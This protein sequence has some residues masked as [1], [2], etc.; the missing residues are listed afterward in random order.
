MSA[1]S[2]S[3]ALATPAFAWPTALFAIVLWSAHGVA[4]WGAWTGRWPA[5][6]VVAVASLCAYGSFTV[7]HEAVHGSLCLKPR[8]LNTVVAMLAAL[9]LMAPGWAFRFLHLEHH[10]HTNDPDQDPDYWNGRG[11]AWALPLRWAVADLAQ[12]AFYFR[13]ARGRPLAERVHTVV[14]LS[15]IAVAL[16]WGV[17]QGHGWALLW[18]WVIP[19][20][21]A[22][23]ALAFSF[24]FIVHRPH[25]VT[26]AQDRLRA[27]RILE[28]P[29]PVG[30]LLLGQHLHL[31]HHLHPGVPFY[32]Y[33][34][35]WN[36]LREVH[37]VLNYM[38]GG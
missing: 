25:A 8:T 31:L 37:A 32:R 38:N 7:L 4:L 28:V 27:T 30:L 13:R 6:A 1:S 10:R 33:R 23:F 15:A 19:A 20:R 34:A 12:W 11:P 9:P 24:D 2:P 3:R 35:A 16:A 36:D 21:V 29:R 14:G 26:A 5:A 18:A 22:V 17:A